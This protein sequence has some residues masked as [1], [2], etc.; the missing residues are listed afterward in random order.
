MF[1]TKQM[2]S[3]LSIAIALA[4]A[5]PAFGA[6]PPVSLIDTVTSQD[7]DTVLM[8]PDGKRVAYVVHHADLAT[9]KNPH[10]LRVVNTKGGE[11]RSLLSADELSNVMWSGDGHTLY[12]LAKRADRYVIVKADSDTGA[13]ADVWSGTTK[14]ESMATAP[15][16]AVAFVTAVPADAETARHRQEEGLVYQWQHDS[17]MDIIDRNYT[18]GDF[19]DIQLI[20]PGSS[21]SRPVYRLQRGGTV[22]QIPLVADMRFSPDGRKIALNLV[23]MGAP[24]QGGPGFNNDVVVLDLDKRELLEPWRGSIRTER[25]PAWSADSKRL[26]F[27]RDSS[28]Q[29]YD[30][31]TR[32]LVPMPW[33]QVSEPNPWFNDLSYDSARNVAHARTKRASYTFDLKRSSV[34]SV[35]QSSTL[36]EA[37]SF[38][39]A[40]ASYAFV[41]QAIEKRPEVAVFDPHSQRTRRLTDL[42]PWIEQ[43]AFG[44]VEKLEVEN[45]SRVKVDAYLVYPV[46]YTT[47]T[48]YPLVIATYGF[49]GKFILGAEWHT[50]FPA[51]A[52]AGQGYA[53]LLLNVPPSGQSVAN[54]QARAR[55]LEGWQM[56]STF[57][58]AA[59]M[60]ISRGIADPER[61]GIYG[62]SHGGFV[63]QFL[64]A[65]S[66]THFKA[67]AMGEGGDYN[68]TE[69]SAFGMSAWPQIFQN[70]Y[71]GPLSA[72]TAKAYL[73]FAPVLSV[74]NFRAP[75]L[76]EFSGRDGFFG[77][78]VYVPMRMLKIPAELVTYD[79]EPHNF[80]TPRARLASMAR[81]VDWF[82]YWMLDKEDP[83]PAKKEQYERWRQL[84]ADWPAQAGTGS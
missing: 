83:S 2:L 59:K 1:I 14:V 46:G 53:V 10:S 44:H 6:L 28:L 17:F 48:R 78:E 45:D 15:N 34:K 67:A 8:R 9:N 49:T 63:V 18:H 72:R 71:G 19:D 37:A 74:A 79:D 32:Q 57:D 75:M 23:R 62:W 52:L 73:D 21:T 31:G 11:E 24:A 36:V 54:D 80:V 55:D 84:R 39:A 65:H 66:K 69:Y 58:H 81:K 77:L 42:N 27:F 38:D 3:R 26:L 51:Q 5:A 16:G 13:A 25:M 7:I 29:L 60:L 33:A 35:P 22:A 70:M 43:R 68:P 41:D 30:I 47:G 20:E 82:N 76:M 4:A 56:L 50:T 12:G 61:M 64:Q 40:F